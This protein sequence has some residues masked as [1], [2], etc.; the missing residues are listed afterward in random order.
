MCSVLRIIADD[1]AIHAQRANS[2][3]QLDQLR[4]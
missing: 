4:D 1:W 2:E 3:D